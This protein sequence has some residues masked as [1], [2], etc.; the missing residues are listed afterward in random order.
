MT[1]FSR[2]AGSD[3]AWRWAWEARSVNGRGLDLRV[4]LPPGLDRIDAAARGLATTRFQRGSLSLALVVEPTGGPGEVRIDHARLQAYLAIAAALQA[5][6]GIAPPRA[7]GLLALRGVIEA[8]E[9]GIG[10][11]AQTGPAFDTAVLETLAEAL[12]GLARA[13]AEEGARLSTVLG[14]LLREILGLVDRARVRAAAQPAALKTRMEQQLAE[15]LGSVPSLPP[16]R[17][18]QEVAVLA[19]RADVAEELARLQAH[20]DQAR[21]LLAGGTGAGRKLEFLAQ[22]FN[23]EA[24]TMCSKSSDLELTR[25]GLDLKAQIDRLREQAAN[26]E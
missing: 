15:L 9:R 26:V 21:A 5:D 19:T 17:L 25:I 14:D 16:D 18:A 13:R 10:D 2:A 8:G 7:D 6:H 3:D 23:R 1:G 20:V 12:D 4:R 22:E 24:N 11:L